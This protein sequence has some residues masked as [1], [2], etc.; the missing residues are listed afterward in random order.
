MANIYYSNARARSLEV[1]LLG[2]ERI[3]RMIDSDT[4][5]GVL[6]ILSEVNFGEGLFVDSVLD[7]EKLITAEMSSFYSFVRECSPTLAFKNFILLKNDFHNAQ[8][9][10]RHKYLKFDETDLLGER[11]LIDTT[12]LKDKIMIDDYSSFPSSLASALLKADEL[13]VSNKATGANIDDLFVKG[14]YGELL[15]STKK[16]NFLRKLVVFKIDS[17]NLSLAFRIR[18]FNVAK[19][20]YLSGGKISLDE[21]KVLCELSFDEIKNKFLFSDYHD[22]INLAILD[23]EENSSL[24]CFEKAVDDYAL[25]LLLKHKYTISKDFPFIQYCL[26][27]LADINNAR[28]IAV[29]AI[30]KIKKEEIRDR[31]RICYEG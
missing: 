29:G 13:F 3:N 17:L 8:A 19:E 2:R 12:E 31:L 20:F 6:K 25:E 7:F 28:L 14:L 30:N 21:F 22:L 11:G 26:Y 27:K 10:I 5:D 9:I 1:K 16:H 23:K 24:S 15:L 18:N 4:A